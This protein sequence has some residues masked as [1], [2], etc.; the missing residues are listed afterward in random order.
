MGTLRGRAERRQRGLSN[1]ELRELTG[2]DRHQVYRL[3]RELR[4]EVPE[5]ELTGTGRGTR[6][7]FRRAG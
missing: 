5:L 2:L 1:R 6:Y 3:L 4:D 7:S